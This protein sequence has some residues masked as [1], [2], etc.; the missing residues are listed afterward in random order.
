MTETEQDRVDTI[1]R[2]LI[3]DIYSMSVEAG[4]STLLCDSEERHVSFIIKTVQE[5]ILSI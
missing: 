3:S 5:T 1:G 2:V 4:R